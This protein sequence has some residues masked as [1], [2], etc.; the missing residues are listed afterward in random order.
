MKICQI[1]LFVITASCV[2]CTEEDVRLVEGRSVFEGRVEVC[3]NNAWST[4]CDNGWGN[5]DARVVCTELGFTASGNACKTLTANS[6]I[7]I[8]R[9]SS[10]S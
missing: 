9:S 6:N 10:H 1:E 2:G 7:I 4:V 3:Y 8:G 5:D